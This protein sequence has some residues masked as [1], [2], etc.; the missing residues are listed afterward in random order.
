MARIPE[1]EIERLKAEVAVERLAEARGITLERHGA[2]LIGLCPFHDDREPSLVITP[3]KNLWH[4]LGACQAGG[5]VID[6]VMRTEGISFR[7]AVERMREDL[8]SLTSRS[9]RDSSKAAKT[10]TVTKLPAPFEPDADDAALLARVVAY[11]H[12]ALKQSTEATAYLASRGLTHP[13][14]IDR[15]QLGFANRTLGYRLP[16]KN[17]KEGAEIRGRLQKLGILRGSGH[18]HLNGSLV[19]PV[20]DAQGTVAELYG[21]KITPGLRKG[22]PLHLYLPGPHRGVWNLEALQASREIIL[23]ESLIDAMTFWSAGFRNVTAAYG[24]EGMT[25]DHWR[26]FEARGTQRVLIA[27]DRDTAGEQAA[28]KLAKELVQAGIDAYRIHFPRGMDANEYAQ[29]LQPATKSLELLIRKAGWLGKGK[30]PERDPETALPLRAEVAQDAIDVPDP[31][32][33]PDVIADAPTEESTAALLESLDTPPPSVAPLAARPEPPVA[34][35]EPAL[36]PDLPAL[37]AQGE[38]LAMSIGDRRWRIRGITKNTSFDALRVNVGVFR[39]GAGFHVDSLDLYSARHRKAFIQEAAGEVELEQRVVKKD[40]GQVLL[41]LEAWQEEA[42]QK[43]LEPADKEVVLSEAEQK[44]ALD[45][46][47]DPKLLDRILADFNRCGVVGEETNKLVGYLAAVSRKLEAPLAVV[48]QSS[49]AA[50]KSWLMESVLAFMPEEERV[51]YSAMTGQSLFYMGETDL[52][53]KILAIVEEEGAERASYA[54]KLLQ[55][56]GELT[57]ASTGKDPSSG[58]L[59]THEYHVQGPVMIFLTTTAM[60][61]DEEL[62]NRC[63]VLTV[64]EGREQTRAIHRL[65]RERQ[66]LEGLLEGQDRQQVLAVHRNAQRLLRPLLVA[67]PYARDLT[68]PGHQT[69]TR[70]DHMKYLT[71]IRTVTLLHQ[72]QRTVKTTNHGGKAVR[73][74]EVTKD[75]IVI[76]NRLAHEVLGRSLDELAPQ[77]RRLLDLVCEMVKQRCDEHGVDRSDLRFTRRDI[78][79]WTGWGNTQLK[80]HLHR[81]EDLEYLLVHAGGRGQSFVY[82]MAYEAGPQGDAPL[83][84]GLIDVDQLSSPSSHPYDEKKSG[85]NEEKSGP[86]RPQVGGMSGG[87]RPSPIN[88]KS[89]DPEAFR[90]SEANEL[91][92]ALPDEA[93]NS[94]STVPTPSLRLAAAASPRRSG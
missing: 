45:L 84:A 6:W 66:T 67:N 71:L 87:G 27:Y 47:Q 28:E 77:T 50:G 78:R 41:R 7:H 46:L 39:E 44:T 20:F 64:N 15:F 76:A 32:A 16:M 43:A 93:A 8:P 69:R 13:E 54:L 2:D 68:F 11:Y 72:Y 40:L 70:R 65:Q 60:E 29:K 85:A 10:S 89:S 56:E 81:L 26:A 86:S 9:S 3:A 35:P 52:Q 59:L 14:L 51:Q 22:T 12:E 23:C 63:L 55:S 18:E 94:P 74:I 92:N 90:P 34:T 42:I 36:P 83:L 75:D 5:S 57:I 80:I 49:S 1:G 48:I 62:L 73:Y 21:R 33:V 88:E 58:K 91:E 19:I 31:V 24:V 61:I 17:R 4:C 25:A 38:E 30:A 82:E 37:E 79:E 53:H